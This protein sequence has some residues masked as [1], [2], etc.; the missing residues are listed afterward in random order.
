[1]KRFIF[2]ALIS[3]GIAGIASAETDARQVTKPEVSCLTTNNQFHISNAVVADVLV[4]VTSIPECATVPV[5][6]FD[7]TSKCTGFVW[8][9]IK[10]PELSSVNLQ[11]N[12]NS[13]FFITSRDWLTHRYH[14]EMKT[15]F[16][17]TSVTRYPQL[18]D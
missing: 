9:I 18:F 7:V 15:N 3:I 17:Y 8:H 1:M 4:Y 13:K 2:L 11:A 12:H 14:L 6:V 16:L 5:L 10:P